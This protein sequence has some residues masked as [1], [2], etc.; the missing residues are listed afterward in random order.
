MS[1]LPS[2]IDR[3]ARW[4][5]AVSIRCPR[6]HWSADEEQ[7]FSRFSRSAVGMRPPPR[8][9]P[10]SPLLSFPPHTNRLVPIDAAPCLLSKVLLPANPRCPP[11]ARRFPVHRQMSSAPSSERPAARS[12]GENDT[13]LGPAG[14]RP[15]LS[16]ILP[17]RWLR[18]SSCWLHFKAQCA[19]EEERRG[20]RR[21]RRARD[22]HTHTQTHKYR[23][24]AALAY[25]VIMNSLARSVNVLNV[26]I[27][28]KSIYYFLPHA[29]HALTIV[30]RV[31]ELSMVTKWSRATRNWLILTFERWWFTA[32]R[33]SMAYDWYDRW[34]IIT[35]L[36]HA[37]LYIP[38]QLQL[39]LYSAN[40]N[41]VRYRSLQY[42]HI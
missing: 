40:S 28:H 5:S 37:K 35:V 12:P 23:D 36:F 14:V 42:Q 34:K 8:L 15:H 10:S 24:P 41:I 29:V 20:E 7:R 22:S 27:A 4:T 31:L 19:R 11:T 9:P 6:F 17:P 26:T 38:L 13:R 2:R 30:F 1:D 16:H 21:G 32:T 33:L 25:G 18:D 39:A 3:P